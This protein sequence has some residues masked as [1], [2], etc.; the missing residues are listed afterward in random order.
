TWALMFAYLSVVF[1]GHK[2]SKA[3][4]IAGFICYFGVFIIATKGEIFSL[5]FSSIFGVFLALLSTILWSMYWIFNTK[6]KSN[7]IVGLFSNFL[8]G[9]IFISIYILLTQDIK[10]PSLTASLGA[11]YVGFFEMGFSFIFWLKA[12]NY[13]KSI[14]KISNLI[15]LSPILSLLFIKFFVGEEIL[16]STIIALVFIL[17]G[18]VIQKRF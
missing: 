17:G 8:V 4:I 3:D 2:I 13:T 18:L 11:I 1:L 15:F 10:L 12:V 7:P 16:S 9:V 6:S 5:H 14:S